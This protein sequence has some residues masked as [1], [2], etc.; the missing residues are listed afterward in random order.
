M[1]RHQRLWPA[2]ERRRRCHWSSPGRV[3]IGRVGEPQGPVRAGD[4]VFGPPPAGR[5]GSRIRRAEASVNQ[6]AP[7]GPDVMNCGS[8]PDG[9]GYSV[10]TPAVVTRAILLA[11]N[12]VNQSAPSDPAA[13]PLESALN[14]GMGKSV[15][16]PAGVMRPTS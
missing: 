15:T 12:S 16:T 10:T 11:W 13:M 14:V 4:D 6:R 7:S 8:P 1:S 5:V 2:R 3:G 9:S